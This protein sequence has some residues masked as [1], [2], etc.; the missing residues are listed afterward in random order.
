MRRTCTKFE[1]LS[2][3]TPGGVLSAVLQTGS[4]FITVKQ[5]EMSYQIFWL[6][7]MTNNSSSYSCLIEIKHRRGHTSD[8][9]THI[10][11]SL[12]V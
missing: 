2:L 8:S 6:V 12:R 1:Y 4:R 3:D 5:A 7:I 9:P 11:E 10:Y